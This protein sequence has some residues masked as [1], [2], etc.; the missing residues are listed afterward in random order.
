MKK[1]L[2]GFA[3]VV[4]ALVFLGVLSLLPT[5]SLG[6]RSMD[7]L[8][9]KLVNVYYSE[10]EAGARLVMKVAEQE[11][12]RLK[13]ILA[14]DDQEV[15]E[16]ILYGKQLTMQSKKYGYLI[17]FTGLDNYVGEVING[18][19]LLSA[20]DVTDQVIIHHLTHFYTR[21][22]NPDLTYWLDNGLAT[23]LA[24]QAPDPSM[25]KGSCAPSYKETHAEGLLLPWKFEK[26]AGHEFSYSYI[27][28]LTDTYS[29]EQVRSLIKEMDYEES[30]A[31]TEKAIYNEWIKDLR[32]KSG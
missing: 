6:K 16:I 29:W 4:F 5:L 7:V 19:I 20:P 22:I 30:F 13:E 28:F 25:L 10:S 8:E 14:L 15:V 2:K 1:G 9:G 32:L 26:M 23:Y 21:K 17:G 12:P 24:G 3:I 31:E 27:Q 11:I 18:A